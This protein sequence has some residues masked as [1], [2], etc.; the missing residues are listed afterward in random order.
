[1]NDNLFSAIR[2]LTVLLLSATFG[3]AAPGPSI[4][5]DFDVAADFASYQTYGFASELGTD[6][7]GYSTLITGHFKQAVS[8]ELEALGYRLDESDP[9]LIVNFF[10][11]VRNRTDVRST[12]AATMGVGYFG[13]RYGLYTSWPLYARD[14]TTVH[15]RVGTANV[16]VVDADRRQLI[17]E[18]IAEGR[19]SD[20]VINNPR[21]AIDSVV[22]ELFTRYPARAGMAARTTPE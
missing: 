22:T 6:R 14:V 21:P 20:D 12:P 7:A 10:A 19:L 2:A 17:W 16:D 3:C 13:Y 5:T 18:G 9:D 4:R 11:T 8:R 15:Y 1:M